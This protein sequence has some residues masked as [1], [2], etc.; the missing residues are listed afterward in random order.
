MRSLLIAAAACLLALC[1]SSIARAV[2]WPN[3]PGLGQLTQRL[4]VTV[5]NPAEVPNEAALVHLSLADL[6][7]TLPDAKL[8]QLVVMDPATPLAKREQA[9]ANFVPFQISSD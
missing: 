1:S 2:D 9:D 4:A 7:K 6:S 3:I 8:D 5:E